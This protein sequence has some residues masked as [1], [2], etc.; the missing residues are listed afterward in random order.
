[1]KILV[2]HS[3]VAP[4]APPE[5]QDTL[6]AADAVAKA[7]VA[8]GYEV[9]RAPFR[10]ERLETDLNR[11]RPDIVFNLVEGIDGQGRLAP[12]APDMLATLGVRFTGVNARAMALTN[13]K[14]RTKQLLRGVGLATPDWA[15]PPDWR[16]VDAGRWIVK[17]ALEDASLGLDDR[18]VVAAKEVPARAAAATARFGGAWFAERYIEGREF[19]VSLLDAKGSCRVLPMAEMRFEHWP[20]GKPRIVGHDAK[21]EE[22]SS[23]WRGT[24]RAFGVERD[25]PELAAKLKFASERVWALFDLDG[26]VRVDFRVGS[27]GEPQVLEINANPGISPDAGFAAAAAEAG[28]SYE[29]LIEAIVR[30]ANQEKREAPSARGAVFRPAARPES[31]SVSQGRREVLKGRGTAFRPAVRQKK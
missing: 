22:G 15:V 24:V 2:L 12:V 17:S 26:F 8:R 9:A 6:V 3:D 14:P 28:L 25:E 4:D 21:W 13:D 20:E 23:D 11:I 18:S 7:L 29:D 27:D 5:D 10:Q 16:G 30:S 19:N 31:P 1:M